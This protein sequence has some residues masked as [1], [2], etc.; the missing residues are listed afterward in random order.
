MRL[1][2]T[3]TNTHTHSHIHTYIHTHTHTHT[4]VHVL[5]NTVSHDFYGSP[6]PPGAHGS[7]V[8]APRETEMASP[9]SFI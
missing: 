6:V 2:H 4:H 3:R 8:L 7:R 9:E 1:V 5:T